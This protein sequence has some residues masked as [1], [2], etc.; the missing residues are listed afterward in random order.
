VR[1]EAEEARSRREFD[2]AA[3]KLTEFADRALD[4]ERDRALALRDG[5]LRARDDTES[6]V[7]TAADE[8]ATRFLEAVGR[9]DYALARDA[10]D[11]LS[12][13]AA[14]APSKVNPASEF[15]A[16]GRRLL[17]L[18]ESLLREPLRA[19][20][21]PGAA[22]DRGLHVR[23][24][25]RYQSVRVVRLA[26]RE[27]TIAHEGGQ[28]ATVS[29][30]DVSLDDV[31]AYAGLT[32]S[33]P[34]RALVLAA[35]RLAEFAP[36]SDPA[37]DAR[38]LG[39]TAAL[40]DKA[41]TAPD[42][43]FMAARLARLCEEEIAAARSQRNEI[44]QR[45]EQIHR[46]ALADMENGDFEKAHRQLVSLLEMKTLRRTD[47]V[48]QRRDEIER[49]RDEAA[50]GRQS[51]GV[52]AKFP[53]VVFT[54]GA[55]GTT[56]M[57]VDFESSAFV[58]GEARKVLGLVE[59]RTEVASRPAVIADRPALVRPTNGG[60]PVPLVLEHAL[61]WRPG[62]QANAPRE[63]PVSIECPFSMR[64]RIAVSFAYRS[65]DPSFFSVSIGCVTAGILSAP[66]ERYWGRGIW[67]WGAKD[68]ARPDKE[69]DDRYRA[70]YQARHPEVLK[71]EGDRRFFSF[72]PGRTYRVE[73][74]KDERKAGVWVDG[75]LRFEGEWRPVSG[76]L[77]GKVVLTSFG[78]AEVDDLRITGIL[79]PEW[80]KGK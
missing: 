35:V 10:V 42:L 38:A 20:L 21:A 45:A 69:F 57:Y 78:A 61:A 44:E 79:D 27:L 70:T 68:L 64:S 76:V 41:R 22:L 77:D 9:R 33:D 71:K 67:I 32:P 3:A 54:R 5:L 29:L 36:G 14:S 48:R 47:Y 58:T 56:E 23:S 17:D 51:S 24:G 49:K 12:V 19:R 13:V 65:P 74:V 34:E 2:A 25:I 15:A 16:G 1:R 46:A 52:A 37:E 43:Q 31:V 72:E 18:I 55:D 62:D 50:A 66:D 4:P 73:V 30:D 8:T 7:R 75:Q 26:G 53:G 59:G 80:L 60:T 28:T 6:M 39:E 11:E 40:V 63:F